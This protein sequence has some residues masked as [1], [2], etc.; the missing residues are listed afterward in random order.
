MD[1][2]VGRDRALALIRAA[3][4]S[5]TEV[6]DRLEAIIPRVAEI[7]RP[8]A[9]APRLRSI[10]APP[11][12]PSSAES[13]RKVADGLDTFS[14]DLARAAGELQDG[15]LTELAEQSREWGPALWAS[16]L[17]VDETYNRV[18][19]ALVELCRRRA[20]LLTGRSLDA[21]R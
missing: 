8:A 12:A 16:E 19:G 3:L 11:A 1:E 18:R 9:L 13:I 20:G 4:I 2:P 17:A 7:P 15:Q 21:L 5:G 10:V 14:L 6:E